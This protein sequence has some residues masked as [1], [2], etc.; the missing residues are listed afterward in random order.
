MF[1]VKLCVCCLSCNII[2]LAFFLKLV[3][4][5]LVQPFTDSEDIFLHLYLTT[6]F[7]LIKIKKQ[8]LEITD[9]M[10]LIKDMENDDFTKEKF[11]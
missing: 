11:S 10:L 5:I 4:F 6:L 7:Y 9:L 3:A 8:N 2:F 1:F